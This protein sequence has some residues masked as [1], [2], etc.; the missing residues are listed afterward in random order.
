MLH[1]LFSIQIV[2][3]YYIYLQFSLN[4]TISKNEFGVNT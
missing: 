4:Q 2:E 3:E 1:Q